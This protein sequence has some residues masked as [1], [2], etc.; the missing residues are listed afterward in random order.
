MIDQIAND[1]GGL[2]I[3]INNAGTAI[4]QPFVESKPDDWRRQIDACLYGAIHCCHAAAPHLNN[5]KNGRIV[6]VVGDSSRVG[7]FGTCDRRRRT[8][9]RHRAD[10]I[11]GA[12]IRPF[13][14]DG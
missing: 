10:E 13:R 12:R 7:E 11:A 6:G 4:R 3:L 2:N 5:A 1:F 9:R 8:R 14:H